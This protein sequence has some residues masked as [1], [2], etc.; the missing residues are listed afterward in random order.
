[1][2]N[3]GVQ[4]S[5]IAFASFFKKQGH[6]TKTALFYTSEIIIFLVHVLF[7]IGLEDMLEAGLKKFCCPSKEGGDDS[8]ADLL[9]DVGNDGSNS[10]LV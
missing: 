1:M 7:L 10:C 9:L 3:W 4:V 8:E 2:V 5:F 6:K